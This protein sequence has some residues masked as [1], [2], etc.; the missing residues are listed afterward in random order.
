MKKEY[1]QMLIDRKTHEEINAAKRLL[2]SLSGRRLSAREVIGEFLG[3]R[4]RFLSLDSDIKTYINAF[5]SE[6]ALDSSVMGLLLF[7]SVARG[8]FNKHSDIDV[9]VVVKGRAMSSFER[10][11]DMINRVELAREPLVKRGLYLRIRPL[12]LSTEE[13][14][15]FRPIYLDI[16][17]DGVVLFERN[18]TIFNF[19]NDIRRN[20]DYRKEI[21]G[22]NVVVR[23]RIKA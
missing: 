9:L 3:R 10:V 11:D 7:G 16:L 19:L 22:N 1:K 21:V 18:D 17:E 4:L 14:S 12:L 20:V 15:N 13:L 5:V 23:W 2:G 8:E 6:A